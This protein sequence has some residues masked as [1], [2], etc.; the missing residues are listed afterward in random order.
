MGN[1]FISKK[2]HFHC[3]DFFE[4]LCN[5]R[6]NSFIVKSVDSSILNKLVFGSLLYTIGLCISSLLLFLSY[7]SSYGNER[8]KSQSNPVIFSRIQTSLHNVSFSALLI[9]VTRF[10]H[11]RCEPLYL[12]FNIRSYWWIH[13]KSSH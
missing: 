4:T 9:K 8:K 2:G 1:C 10:I 7:R 12:Q 5:H 3:W 11:G 6:S 13:L